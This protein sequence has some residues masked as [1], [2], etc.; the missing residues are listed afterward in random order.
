MV[1]ALSKIFN[2]LGTHGLSPSEKRGLLLSLSLSPASSELIWATTITGLC[3]IFKKGTVTEDLAA[4]I[5][6]HSESFQFKTDLAREI[7][8][9]IGKLSFS[10]VH[11]K[12][13]LIAF[14]KNVKERRPNHSSNRGR[15]FLPVLLFFLAQGKREE[16]ELSF[17]NSA[18]S[19]LPEQ[20]FLHLISAFSLIFLTRF[21]FLFLE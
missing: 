11:L 5:K 21:S 13:N 12:E 20:S 14:L 4:A 9:S 18:G 17:E 7:H 15:T 16:L 10:D 8:G 19:S 1:P 2:F 3:S 6:F